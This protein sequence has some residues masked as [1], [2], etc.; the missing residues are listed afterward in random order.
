M[1]S[2]IFMLLLI[3]FS[4]IGFVELIKHLALYFTEGPEEKPK[5]DYLLVVP[6]AGHCEHAEYLLRGAAAKVKWF[7]KRSISQ[8]ICIDCDMD[9]TTKKICS[10]V[11]NDYAFMVLYTQDEFKQYFNTSGLVQNNI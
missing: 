4:V 1:A 8:V 9:E 2:Y 6:I 10:L 11:C 7:G 5:R 3:V